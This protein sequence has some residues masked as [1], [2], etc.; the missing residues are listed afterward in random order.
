MDE[1]LFALSLFIL[2]VLLAKNHRMLLLMLVGSFNMLRRRIQHTNGMLW[3]YFFRVQNESLQLHRTTWVHPKPQHYFEELL[4]NNQLDFQWKLH[5]RVDRETFEFICH[6][7]AP[8]KQREDTN[9]SVAVLV[10]KRVAASLW[11]LGTSESYRSVGVS[12]GLGTS[13][14]FYVTESF[15]D[16]LLSHLYDF[17]TFPETEEETRR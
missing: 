13:S 15:M 7:V 3:Q 17:I 9:F 5:F 11:K 14:T 2:L 16:S 12:I 6:L 1:H 4:V 10:A 8:D